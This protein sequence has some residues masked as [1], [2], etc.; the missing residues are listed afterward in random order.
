MKFKVGDKV[1]PKYNNH[2]GIVISVENDGQVIYVDYGWYD[3]AHWHE[4]R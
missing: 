2:V 1:S 3:T 4:H